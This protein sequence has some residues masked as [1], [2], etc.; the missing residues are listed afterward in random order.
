M[1]HIETPFRKLVLVCTNQR[2]T[3]RECCAKKGSIDFHQQLKSAI[4]AA[5]SDVRVSKAGCLGTCTTGTTVVIMPDN[6]WLGDVKNADIDKIV[7]M[8]K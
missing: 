2:D 8:L 6:I 7:T 3:S 5:F 1:N 4:K